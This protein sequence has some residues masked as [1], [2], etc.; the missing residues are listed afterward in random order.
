VRVGFSA[1]P[2]APPIEPDDAPEPIKVD[3]WHYKDPVLQTVQK[4]N[5]EHWT[6]HMPE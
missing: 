5:A 6:V 4:V 1:R 3:L 2:P